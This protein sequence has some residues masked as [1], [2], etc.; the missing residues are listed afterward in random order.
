MNKTLKRIVSLLLAV[1]MV[2]SCAV[3]V[4]A[5]EA[6]VGFKYGDITADGS[7]NSSDA[8]SVLRHSVGAALLEGNAFKAADVNGDGNINSSDALLILQYSV[9]SVKLFPV[10]IKVPMPQTKAEI[11]ALYTKTINEAR[12]EIPAYKL[13]LTSQAIRVDLSGSMVSLMT[14]EEIAAQKENMMKKSEY[15]NLLRAD[16]ATALSNLPA[17]CRVTDPAK[18]KDITCKQLADGNYQI[19]IIFKNEKDPKA[20]SPIVTMLNLPDKATF[21]KT[22]EEDVETTM[23]GSD[24]PVT[25]EVDNMEYQNCSISCVINPRTGELV[26]M[27]TTSD[28]VSSV[29]MYILFYSMTTDTTARTSLAY[30]NFIY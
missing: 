1:F 26:S 21:V 4:S 30:S 11:L 9:G 29:S 18:F 20:G 6:A 7:I 27:N 16:S 2:L 8:L 19:D 22:M 15:Q 3:L 10:E 12:A 5:E 25:V 17:E 28:M 24:I 13:N 23:G 14:K